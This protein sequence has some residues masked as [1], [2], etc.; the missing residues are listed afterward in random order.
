MKLSE[1]TDLY[2][3][4]KNKLEAAKPTKRQKAA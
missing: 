1:L 2:V 4:A 3:E